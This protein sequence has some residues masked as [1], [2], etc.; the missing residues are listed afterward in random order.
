LGSGTGEGTLPLSRYIEIIELPGSL[1][2]IYGA[3]QLRGKI[4]S[5][6]DLA[7]IDRFLLTPLSAWQ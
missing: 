4:L 5:R 3:Q 2:K 6:R 7:P 1:E